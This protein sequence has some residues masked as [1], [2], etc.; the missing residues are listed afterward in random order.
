MCGDRRRWRTAQVLAP[1]A[2]RAACE[3]NAAQA[4]AGDS[5]ARRLRHGCFFSCAAGRCGVVT[6][7]HHAAALRRAPASSRLAPV[8]GRVSAR[9]ASSRRAVLLLPSS[10]TS[11]S[12]RPLSQLHSVHFLRIMISGSRRVEQ[13][14]PSRRG[15]AHGFER[16]RRG[17]VERV[18]VIFS[19]SLF[20]SFSFFLSCS[21]SSPSRFFSPSIFFR[22]T[23]F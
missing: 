9:A 21:F 18:R 3:P 10:F 5:C 14:A 15:V 8:H 22:Y 20:L 12:S 6:S 7:G 2:F 4:A 23:T 11:F 16:E 19:F 17:G 13:G 1:V